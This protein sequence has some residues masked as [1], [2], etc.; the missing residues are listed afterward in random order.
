MPKTVKQVKGLVDFLQFWR[1]FIPNLVEKLLPFF[2]ILRKNVEHQITEEQE[3]A[4][5]ILKQDLQKET[6]LTLRLAKP[7][8]QYVILCEASYCGAGFV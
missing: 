8:L 5:E 6:D 1:D 2:K 4:L 3:K 7:G